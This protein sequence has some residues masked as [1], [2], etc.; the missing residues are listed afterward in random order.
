MSYSYAFHKFVYI[1]H[2]I[3]VYDYI[4][5]FTILVR[6]NGKQFVPPV[7]KNVEDWDIA[8]RSGTAD[9]VTWDSLMYLLTSIDTRTK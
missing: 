4:I 9:G 8:R 3:W 6:C 7:E 1:Y 2:I 5:L